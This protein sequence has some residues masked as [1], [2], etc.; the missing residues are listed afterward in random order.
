MSR[1]ARVE[2]LFRQQRR[3]CALADFYGEAHSNDR[4][5]LA[6]MRRDG[7]H[8][9]SETRL[10]GC[11]GSKARHAHYELVHGPEVR[12]DGWCLRDRHQPKQLA[13]AI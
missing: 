2:D 12:C 8:F 10:F 11:Q 7:W 5:E 13:I 4:N 1:R 3:I 9:T 6:G